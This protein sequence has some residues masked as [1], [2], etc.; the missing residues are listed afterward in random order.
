L[1]AKAEEQ[2]KERV[3]IEEEKRIKE[4]QLVFMENNY[5]T[6]EEEVGEMRDLLK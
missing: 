2:R 5:Q 6:L 1:K 3:R 4:E